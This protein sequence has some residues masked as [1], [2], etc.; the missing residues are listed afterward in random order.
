MKFGFGLGE[1][2]AVLL[3]LFAGEFAVLAAAVVVGFV[4][5]EP[6]PRMSPVSATRTSTTHSMANPRRIGI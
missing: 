6:T 1:D 5:S 2:F 3:G 4:L